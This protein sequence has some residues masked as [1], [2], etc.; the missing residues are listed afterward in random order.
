VIPTI[1]VPILTEP[2]RLDALLESIDHP[3]GRVIVIDNG[4]CIDPQIGGRSNMPFKVHVV[5]LPHNLGVAASWNLGFRCAPLSPYWVVVNSDIEFGAGDLAR[6]E[7]AVESRANAIYYS[8]GMALFA[9]TP[10]ALQAVGTFDEN[11]VLA[12]DEDLDWQRRAR[13]IGTL[14]VEVGFTGK[15]AGSATIMSNPELRAWNHI[16][17]GKNDAY[18]ARKWGGAKQGGETFTTPFNR[19]G[20]VGEWTLDLNRLRDQIWPR[21]R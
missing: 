18:Y 5:H 8:L 7:A 17:H 16:S 15:H 3:V 19:G 11:L 12:Y 9:V 6:L 20:W 14:E 21:E 2:D 4:A 1:V 10:P 13:L